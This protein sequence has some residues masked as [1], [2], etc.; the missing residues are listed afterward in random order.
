MSDGEVEIDA[1]PR[2][3]ARCPYCHDALGEG[4]ERWTCAGC[5]AA[6][7]ADCWAEAG[8]R[9]CVAC[10]SV[11]GRREGGP[12]A[13]PSD[14]EL[15]RILA[16]DGRGA[17]VAALRAAGLSDAASLDRAV[18]VAARAEVARR[19]GQARP[20]ASVLRVQAVGLVVCA[21]LAAFTEAQAAVIGGALTF[22]APLPFL[23]WAGARERALGFAL[24][25]VALNAGMAAAGAALVD[26]LD[27]RRRRPSGALVLMALCCAAL[28]WGL[29]AW[30]ARR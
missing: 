17:V 6:H 27:V 16:R 20:L 15:E 13:P 22:G 1:R 7:H 10:G 30:R 4:K 19:A 26:A 24:G 25:L 11:D 14:A 8:A 29:S 3:G 12:S 18:E 23:L 21:L 2:P 9:S 5:A 28:S